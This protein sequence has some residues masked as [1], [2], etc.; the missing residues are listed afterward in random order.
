VVLFGT[1]DIAHLRTNIA[2]IAAPPLPAGDVDRLYELFGA[3]RGVG[4]DLPDN[5]KAQGKTSP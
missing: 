5:L 2:S 1:S 4:L 3:L